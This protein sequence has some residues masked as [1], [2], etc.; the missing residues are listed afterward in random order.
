MLWQIRVI[1]AEVGFEMASRSSLPVKSSTPEAKIKKSRS[2]DSIEDELGSYQDNDTKMLSPGEAP[3]SSSLP[4]RALNP[5]FKPAHKKTRSEDWSECNLFN[6]SYHS[7][8]EED[9]ISDSDTEE[10]WKK[11][12]MLS[13]PQTTYV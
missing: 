11:E 1:Y 7:Q 9:N 10:E 4:R 13:V 8:E 12:G 5:G 6:N 2:M 3:G